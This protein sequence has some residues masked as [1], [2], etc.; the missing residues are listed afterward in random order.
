VTLC[1]VHHKVVH[2]DKMEKAEVLAWLP[3]LATV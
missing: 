2:A 3:S 1:N